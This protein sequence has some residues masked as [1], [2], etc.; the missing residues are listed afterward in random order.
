METIRFFALVGVVCLVGSLAGVV[1]AAELYRY[2]A[3]VR[4]NRTDTIKIIEFRVHRE[5]FSGHIRGPT[6]KLAQNAK[7][8]KTPAVEY[9]DDTQQWFLIIYKN[10]TNG[11]CYRSE[12]KSKFHQEENEKVVDVVVESVLRVYHG[13]GKRS[14]SQWDEIVCPAEGD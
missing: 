7:S 6:P 14:D 10:L 3:T 11:R 12:C 1:D 5:K 4:N 8:E 13:D 2:E 9:W